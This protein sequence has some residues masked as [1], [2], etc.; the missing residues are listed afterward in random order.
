MRA[1]GQKILMIFQKEKNVTEKSID[2]SLRFY[3]V[4][5]GTLLKFAHSYTQDLWTRK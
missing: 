4:T 1:A 2:F 5:G 3:V